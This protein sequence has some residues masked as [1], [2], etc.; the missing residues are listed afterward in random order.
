MMSGFWPHPES[1]SNDEH[2]LEFAPIWRQTPK[3]VFSRTLKKADWNARVI[4]GNLADEVTAL[5]LVESRT[6]DSRSVLLR[7]QRAEQ[8]G[9]P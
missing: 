4:G 6:F 5:K 3:I 1:M 8:D 7:Y 2:D 9:Q